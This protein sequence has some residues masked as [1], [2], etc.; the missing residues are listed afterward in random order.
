MISQ[1]H[2]DDISQG[3]QLASPVEE[4]Q[5]MTASEERSYQT[6]LLTRRWMSVLLFILGILL[7]FAGGILNGTPWGNTE[8]NNTL[9]FMYIGFGVTF[10]S[11]V[12]GAALLRSWWALLIVPVAFAAGIILGG[13]ILKPLLWG[14]YGS[15]VG[16]GA[17]WPALQ[18]EFGSS[19]VWQDLA[20]IL[21][22]AFWPVI[23]C[24]ALGAWL[25]VFWRKRLKVRQRQP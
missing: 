16:Y 21:P 23:V 14:W 7:P 25:G 15:D 2:Q 20:T 11:L 9:T 10:L 19:I 3:E 1:K 12:V 18:A 8:F 22:Y 4:K 6:P 17:G 24:T 13:Y 5:T